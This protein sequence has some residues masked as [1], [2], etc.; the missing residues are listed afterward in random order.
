[1]SK[2][3]LLLLILFPMAAWTQDAPPAPP[4][5][6]FVVNAPTYACWVVAYKAKAALAQKT[7]EASAAL[8]GAPREL[9]K[10]TV[11]KAGATR[12]IISS[13][14]DG[15]TTERWII[16]GFQ[17]VER[18]GQKDIYMYTSS[19]LSHS[20]SSLEDYSGSDFPE[21]SWLAESNYS[22]VESF[23]KTKCWAFQ[24]DAVSSISS[25]MLPMLIQLKNSSAVSKGASATPPKPAPA[26]FKKAWIDIDTKLPVALDDGTRIQVFT[27]LPAPAQAPEMPARFAKVVKDCVDVQTAKKNKYRMQP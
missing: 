5:A 9:K 3:H 25:K 27:F 11:I 17:L 10:L 12:Q 2:I 24:G 13:W 18:P 14:S 6:P 23:S 19:G 26:I 4:T 15:T 1:M 16:P 21:F 7:N 8:A 22:R 20:S